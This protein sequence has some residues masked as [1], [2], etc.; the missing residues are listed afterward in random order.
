LRQF[1]VLASSQKISIKISGWKW[2]FGSIL[3][4]IQ[5]KVLTMICG[6]DKKSYCF[7][8]VVLK[9]GFDFSTE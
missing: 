5:E 1:H 4:E 6:C 8:L 9:K 7:E 3:K 2:N